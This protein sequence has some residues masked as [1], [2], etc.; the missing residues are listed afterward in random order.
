MEQRDRS[1]LHSFLLRSNILVGDD[2]LMIIGIS[3]L[4]WRMRLLEVPRP[5]RFLRLAS[6]R[7]R[8][9][10]VEAILSELVINSITLG[11]LQSK[12][13][14]RERKARCSDANSR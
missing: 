4:D 1:R 10:D 2:E 5:D 12:E 13:P 7:R 3:W 9:K 8:L 14:S 6:H 11:I